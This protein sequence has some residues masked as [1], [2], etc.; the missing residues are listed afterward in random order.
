MTDSRILSSIKNVDI[1]EKLY[2]LKQF[3]INYLK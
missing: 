2:Y 1:Y 3:N